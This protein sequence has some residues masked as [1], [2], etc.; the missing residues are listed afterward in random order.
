[1][2]IINSFIHKIFFFFIIF[3]YVTEN[4]E[5]MPPMANASTLLDSIFSFIYF[6]RAIFRG[7]GI[8]VGFWNSFNS[9]RNYSPVIKF[10]NERRRFGAKAIWR[11]G[12]LA[13]PIIRPLH[14]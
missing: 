8:I 11:K 12:D 9:P 4:N 14:P 10:M 3:H 5:R 1:M 7:I 6:E 2:G 13:P